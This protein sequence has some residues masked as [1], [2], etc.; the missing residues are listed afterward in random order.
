MKWIAPMLSKTRKKTKKKA[1]KKASKK[2]TKKV[3]K[4]A[5]KKVTKKVAKK[6]IAADKAHQ[7]GHRKMKIAG[8]GEATSDKTR[9]QESALNNLTKG[10]LVRRKNSNNRR[11]ITGAA[12]GKT[13]RITVKD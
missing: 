9:I 13:G 5:S 4:S 11:I 7:P 3:A 1:S 8:I 12:L 2:V 10:D 6:A